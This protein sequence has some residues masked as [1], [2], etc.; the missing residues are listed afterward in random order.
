[1]YIR[2]STIL[3]PIILILGLVAYAYSSEN[4]M[5]YVYGERTCPHCKTQ[6]KYLVDK[7]FR[8]TW[9]WVSDEE[10]SR[11]LDRIAADFEI[12]SGTP[13]MVVFVDGEP[14]AIIVGVVTN[15]RFWERVLNMD[16]RSLRIFYGETLMKEVIAP[17][18][19]RERYIA[20]NPT[21]EA[22]ILSYAGRPPTPDIGEYIPT[23]ILIAVVVGLGIAFL[24]LRG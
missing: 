1:M 17:K 6:A 18:D 15:D 13:T 3:I 8:F 23:I 2:V 9:F 12:V 7:G 10:N 24:R 21:D 16:G 11:Y 5:I 22:D 4:Y 19:F 14:V 20:P